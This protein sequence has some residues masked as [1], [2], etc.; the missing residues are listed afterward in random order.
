MQKTFLRVIRTPAGL[1]LFILLF[2]FAML[3]GFKRV[4]FLTGLFAFGYGVSR[5]IVEYFRV[6]DP[7]F[8]S[9]SNPYGFALRLSDYGI[10]MGQ[11]L[12]LPMVIVGLLLCAGW[13]KNRSRN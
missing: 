8:F 7:Q 1:L 9:P 12:S 6:P 11:V 5:F 13:M 3:G 4:G 2:Y 10:T